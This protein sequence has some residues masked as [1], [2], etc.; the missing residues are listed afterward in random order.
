MEFNPFIEDFPVESEEDWIGE[1]NLI[2]KLKFCARSRANF[3]IV[4][5]E[6]SGK[7]SLLRT[8]FTIAYRKKMAKEKRKLIYFADLSNKSDSNDLG[9]YLADRLENSLRMLI[10]DKEQAS[11]IL[12]SLKMST[13][14]SGKTRFQNLIEDLHEV[15]GYF[16]VVV[17][18]YFEMFT[19]S[20]TVTQEHHDCLRSL[21]E[22]GCMQCIVAT[23]YDLSKDSLPLDIRGS[24]FLQKFTNHIEMPF[25]TKENV[26]QY[27][28]R[29]QEEGKEV[30]SAGMAEHIYNLSGGIPKFVNLLARNIYENYL[31]NGGKINNGEAIKVAR[32]QC[33]I[34]M[35]SWC[36]LL[37]DTQLE[38]LE[39][40]VDT[41]TSNKEYAYYDFTGTRYETAVG[42]LL[43]RGLIKQYEYLDRNGNPVSR[44]YLVRFNSL[45]FQKYC[46]EGKMAEAAK[47]NPL[48][49]IEKQRAGNL[50]G[51]G[52][53]YIIGEVH[54]LYENGAVDESKN[55]EATN[56]SVVQGISAKEFIQMLGDSSNTE[57]LGF[58]IG[59]RLQNHIQN[60]FH[61][62]KLQQA[63]ALPYSD[64][65]EHDEIVDRAFHEASQKIFQ[66][67]EIDSYED[68]IDVSEAELQTLDE[69][70]AIARDRIHQNLKDTLLEKQSE[71]CQFYLKM[72][73]V[74]EEALS[75]PGIEFDDYSAQLIL[76]GKAMEQAL[77]D[78]FFGLFHGVPE[79]AQ[80]SL[81]MKSNIANAKDNFGHMSVSKTFIGNFA[82][83]ISAKLDCLEDLCLHTNFEYFSGR[84]PSDWKVWWN[85][86]SSDIHK[87]RE[88]RN[89]A[90]HADSKSPDKGKLQEMYR[91]L[92]G[93]ENFE[94]VLSRVLT[95]RDLT[96][97]YVVPPISQKA[98][99]ELIGQ[100]AAMQCTKVKPNGGIRGK[101]VETG[102]EVNISPRKVNRYQQQSQTMDKIT[103]NLILNVKITE[104]KHDSEKDFFA[105]DIESIIS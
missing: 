45:L 88:I 18:D 95:G 82:Y 94:G 90:G 52:N 84:I 23:N 30:I 12:A 2:D 13:S 71:R 68:I 56:M 85:E 100:S 78:N 36:K 9:E 70:F 17:M 62:E 14:K 65:V 31:M 19:L 93:D 26:Y 64:S 47:N 99:E 22:S 7:T 63:L 61:R 83:L 27:I 97:K 75:L 41:C 34:I 101:L 53:T 50:P 54:K 76:Y 21:T 60:R 43:L 29:K 6:G 55:V 1:K 24:Y 39:M 20:D 92:V 91:T 51:N 28:A 58:L 37:T 72:A 48:T 25:F 15:W 40:I 104:L 89:M 73:V 44:D 10:E 33:E 16:V 42:A 32:S 98:A 11:E 96:F 4:G 59:N 79:L 103:E 38:V 87:V 5:P 8:T 67:V 102:Y 81:K 80:Y 49:E 77:R 46:R 69:R 3:C 57:D 86:V 35:D 66:D 105:A 74:V